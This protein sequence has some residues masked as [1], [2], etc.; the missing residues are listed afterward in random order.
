MAITENE[1]YNFVFRG[2]LTE[3][4]LDDAGRQRSNLGDYLDADI[5]KTLSLDLLDD[6]EVARAKKMATVYVVVSAFENSVRKLIT[7]VL[8]EEVGADWWEKCVSEERRKK[9]ESRRDEESKNRWH[10]PRGDALLNYAEMSDLANIIRRNIEHFEPYV[11][12]V[13]W[14][15]GILRTIERS[16]NVIMHSG[17]LDIADVERLGV[18]V[19]DWIKQVGS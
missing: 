7:E 15:E 8:L 2:L 14:A 5:A 4:A 3:Q 18:N 17:T 6:E 10:S 19:R 12:T 13:E 11:R 16:R 9:A 1:A